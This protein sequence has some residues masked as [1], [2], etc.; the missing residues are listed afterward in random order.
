MFA[1][2]YKLDSI[3][4]YAK[5]F[6]KVFGDDDS[7][8]IEYKW[9]VVENTVRLRLNKTFVNFVDVQNRTQSNRSE[10]IRQ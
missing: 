1:P 3:R 6:R 9:H 2:E 10:I 5:L 8:M 7:F 4:K